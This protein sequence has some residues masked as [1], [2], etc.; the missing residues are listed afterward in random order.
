MTGY[1]T[2]QG[3]NNDCCLKKNYK[4]QTTESDDFDEQD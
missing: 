1:I 2:L 4:A 3:I